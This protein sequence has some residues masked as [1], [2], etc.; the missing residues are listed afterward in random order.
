MPGVNNLYAAISF[1]TFY[2]AC[3]VRRTPTLA[4]RIIGSVACANTMASWSAVRDARGRCGRGGASPTFMALS[5]A[6]RRRGSSGRCTTHANA[7]CGRRIAALPDA[8]IALVNCWRAPS[9][10]RSRCT[11][12]AK[13]YRFFAYFTLWQSDDG[14]A[15]YCAT[16]QGWPAA[17]C[18]SHAAG[19][20][21]RAHCTAAD[22]VY[23]PR[24]G[25]QAGRLLVVRR[26]PAAYARV[27]G[28]PTLVTFR[29]KS[30]NVHV[31]H[32]RAPLYIVST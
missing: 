32:V 17:C 19:S 11:K 1:A 2:R 20:Q 31:V 26:T 9:G 22:P 21:P 16:P 27:A 4:L 18:Q 23:K 5:T 29:A 3:P 7:A 28:R 14:P 24:D 10:L 8:C 30:V 15:A 13:S 25:A 12:M 6:T